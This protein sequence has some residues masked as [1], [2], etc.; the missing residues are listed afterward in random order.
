MIAFFCRDL[1]RDRRVAVAPFDPQCRNLVRHHLPNIT[2]LSSCNVSQMASSQDS[3]DA[4]HDSDMNERY[5]VPYI[6]IA[7]KQE[8]IGCCGRALRRRLHIDALSRV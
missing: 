3:V 2:C 7:T 4:K 6:R 8:R 1:S 5:I